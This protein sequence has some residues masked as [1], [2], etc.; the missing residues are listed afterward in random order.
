[1]NWPWSAG[2]APAAAR[3]EVGDIAVPPG[4][5][6]DLLIGPRHWATDPERNGYK[7]ALPA[8]PQ[9]AK[10]DRAV[11][12]AGLRDDDRNVSGNIHAILPARWRPPCC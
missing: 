9:R 5:S 11:L 8:R 10:L 1:M 6:A 4:Y 7:R 12:S 2:R 3:L